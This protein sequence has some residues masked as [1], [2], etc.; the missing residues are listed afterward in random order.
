MI[1]LAALLLLQSQAAPESPAAPGPGPSSSRARDQRVL[2]E[3][4]DGRLEERALE[5]LATRT[6]ADVGAAW[7][8][9]DDPDPGT[10][11]GPDVALVTLA[12]GD[13]LRG[14]IA[15]GDLDALELV[16]VGEVGLRLSIDRIANLV[17]P[18]RLPAEG[19]SAL[20]PAPEGD[21]LYRR[22][23]ESLDRIDGA[24]EEFGE[25]GL[26]FDSVLGR[27]TFAWDQVGALFVESLGGGEPRQEEGTRVV[28]DL[29]DGG[30]LRGELVLLDENGCRL[31][32]ADGSEL[33]L[34]AT[35]LA[36]VSLDDGSV[37]FLSDLPVA[38]AEEGSPFGDDLGMAWPHRR[39]RAVDGAPLRAGGRV[40]SRGIGVHSPSRL[41]FALDGSWKELRGLVAIDDQVLRLPARGS[42]VFRI[43]VDGEVAWESGVVRGGMPPVAIPT[44]AL[45]G[46]VEL[47]LECDMASELHVADRADWLRMVLVRR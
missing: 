19:V 28:C 36:E 18:A 29:V 3:T 26:V 46:A 30:R 27:R 20:S 22:I 7:I 13:R 31:F 43:R 25:D 32:V 15:G 39:D 6:L 1:L 2:L 8:R 35:A 9:F 10:A 34:P 38:N 41:S 23:G 5:D 14:R 40:F 42:V 47:T 24:V 4:P 45:E 17:F 16:V 44:V 21:R 37:A 33:V 12:G 11:E